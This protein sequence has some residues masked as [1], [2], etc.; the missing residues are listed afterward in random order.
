MPHAILPSRDEFD[1]EAYLRLNPDVAAAIE[2][3][4]VGSA[5][6]HFTLHGIREKRPFQAKPNR[7]EGVFPGIAVRD[8]MFLGDRDH[9]FDVGETA[10]HCIQ[11]ALSDASRPPGTIQRILDL[12]CGH[13]RAL[14]FIRKAFPYAHLTACDLNA[15][16]VAFCAERFGAEPVVSQTDVDAIPLP[17]GFDLIWCG[18]LFTHLPAGQCISFLRLFQRALAPG[19]LLVLTLHGRSYEKTIAAGHEPTGLTK[20]QEKSLLDQYRESGFGYVDY[21][22]QSGYGFSLTH[23]DFVKSRFLTP[24]WQLIRHREQGWNKRQDVL[25]LRKN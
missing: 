19:G 15:D 1:S 14:R 3:G 5:W 22:G 12:P 18:S 4:I 20:D 23:P 17:G 13:G 11:T 21:P 25:L 6:Q 24:A 16:G 9:Y 10:L 7:M 2:R 8:E